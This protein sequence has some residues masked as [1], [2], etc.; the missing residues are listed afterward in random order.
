MSTTT[1]EKPKL[2]IRLENV[3][4]SYPNLFKARA[5]KG[6]D[7]A[8]FSADFI[9][10]KKA[11]KDQIARLEKL[12]ERAMIDKFGKKVGIKHMCLKDGNDPSKEDIE[13]Y[14]DDVM[15]LTAKSDTRPAVVDNKKNPLTEEDGKIYG[16]CYVNASVEI[17]GFKHEVG[18][19]CILASL[20][21]VQ[22][23]RDGESLGGNTP[24]DVDKEFEEV[25]DDVDKY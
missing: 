18:G 5:P 7:K 19:N 6:S 25:E 10:D 11:H 15:Y 22:F 1:E 21:A 8:K 3:R 12:C 23:V 9:L 14:G 24:V 20:R 13:G 4:L 2:I 16:G 17:Y